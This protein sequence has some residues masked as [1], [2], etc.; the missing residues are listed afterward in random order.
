MQHFFGGV[1]LEDEIKE[2]IVKQQLIHIQISVNV[3]HRFLLQ[4]VP[5]LG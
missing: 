3:G 5:Q 1:G 4:D 2:I